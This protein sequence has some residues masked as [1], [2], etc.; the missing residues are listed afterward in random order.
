MDKYG[1][2]LAELRVNFM[3]TILYFLSL[4]TARL[5][6]D[7]LSVIKHAHN[8]LIGLHTVNERQLVAIENQLRLLH[9]H[10]EGLE[11]QRL[12]SVDDDHELIDIK[13]N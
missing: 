13:F 2:H 6:L 11:G 7:T 1:E 4:P 12:T 5:S 10:M 9:R 3:A 8:V